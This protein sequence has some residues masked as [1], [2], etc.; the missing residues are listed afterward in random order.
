VGCLLRCESRHRC[1]MTL[2]THRLCVACD[3]HAS[4][5][6]TP[7]ACA[8]RL[9]SCWQRL[10]PHHWWRLGSQRRLGLRFR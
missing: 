8:A 7:C 1:R 6:V 2:F 3:T 10:I 5:S 4:S 9:Q